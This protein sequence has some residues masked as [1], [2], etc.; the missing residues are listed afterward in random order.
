M[1][2]KFFIA[3][4]VDKNDGSAAANIL[5]GHIFK[6]VGLSRARGTFQHDGA[7]DHAGQVDGRGRFEIGKYPTLS[8]AARV[9]SGEEYIGALLLPVARW[10]ERRAGCSLGQ[11]KGLVL[12]IDLVIWPQP[13]FFR[14]LEG[15]IARPSFNPPRWLNIDLL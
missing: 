4:S 11:M 8:S 6:E 12:G 15:I 14:P 7:V 5:L 10:T 1:R 9:S 13:A 3:L 2:E